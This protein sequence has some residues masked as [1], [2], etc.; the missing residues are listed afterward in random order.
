MKAVGG[1]AHSGRGTPASGE[2]S[3][4]HYELGPEGEEMDTAEDADVI[5]DTDATDNQAPRYAALGS[6]ADRYVFPFSIYPCLRDDRVSLPFVP[7][8]GL[9]CPSSANRNHSYP[10][11]SSQLVPPTFGG[12]MFAF[13]L[14][15]TG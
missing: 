2:E 13:G 6:P 14:A 11:S 1:T 8:Y 15:L 4:D 3:S 9:N 12:P 10:W 5:Q 7:A